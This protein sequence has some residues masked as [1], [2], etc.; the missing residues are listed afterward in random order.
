MELKGDYAI[1]IAVLA[2]L[3]E[4]EK[5]E[6]LA[7]ELYQRAYNIFKRRWNDNGLD[8]CSKGWFISVAEKVN[9]QEVAKELRKELRNNT[10]SR[11]YSL[12]NT[13]FGTDKTGQI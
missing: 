5:N 1:A 6:T 3:E 9:E 7:V 12:E 4:A 10:Q 11:G 8:N 13:L 2:K